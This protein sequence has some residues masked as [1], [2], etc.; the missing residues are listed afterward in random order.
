M[1]LGLF[2]ALCVPIVVGTLWAMVR[3][4][5]RGI[6]LDVAALAIA[7][8]LGESTCILAYRFYRYA[9]DWHLR[10]GVVPVLVPLIWPLVI[11]SARDVAKALFGRFGEDLRLPLIVGLVVAFDAS[12]VEVA[13]VRAG[14][15]SWAE[16]GHLG[17]PVIGVL[18]WG[19]F[20]GG[21][22]WALGDPATTTNARRLLAIAAGPLTAHALI[23][24]SWH[25]LFRWTVRGELGH[26]GLI[27]L[28]VLS[29]LIFLSISRLRRTVGALPP[30]V[31]LPRI[32]AALLFFALVVG[33]TW[34][35]TNGWTLW[36][37]TALVASPYVYATLPTR[38]RQRR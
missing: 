10:L 28:G 8:F 6:L 9:P 4:H 32:F 34:R 27:G 21:A 25:A 33:V 3:T 31:V 17:V 14:Y 13:A 19:F 37:H 36:V 11:L 15:W 29:G 38:T 12:L 16:P 2:E 35:A 20:A 22:T 18:G 7:G 30:A 24:V 1:P 23:L 26:A 5:G